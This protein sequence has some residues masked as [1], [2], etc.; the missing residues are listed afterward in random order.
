M[1]GCE[2]FSAPFL[3]L[4]FRINCWNR[5]AVDAQVLLSSYFIHSNDFQCLNPFSPDIEKK[6][7][8]WN[9]I[10][11]LSLP[12]LTQKTL[13]KS[14]RANLRRRNE[15]RASVLNE[16]PDETDMKLKSETWEQN[17]SQNGERTA[18]REENIYTKANVACWLNVARADQAEEF[19]L[20]SHKDFYG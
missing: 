12:V 11:F 13:W 7:R 1:S 10:F 16:C 4:F 17:E 19:L 18:R 3:V 8:D 2:T 14:S 15:Q 5:L 20:L 6:S 9:A